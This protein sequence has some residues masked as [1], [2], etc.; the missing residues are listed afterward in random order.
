MKYLI[1]EDDPGLAQIIATALQDTTSQVD[2]SHN[3]REGL[4]K[5]QL[6]SYDAII[7]D[8]MLPEMSGINIVHHLRKNGNNT[9][10]MI[11]SALG[12][13]Q[14][15]IEGL[16]YGADDY[17]PKPFD[18]LELKLRVKN[19]LK[20]NRSTTAPTQ[21]SYK[22]L[23]LDRLTRT[24]Q[25]Q[26][27]PIELQEKEYMLL[28]LFLSHPTEVISKSNILKKVWNYDYDPD[29]NIVDVLVCRLRNKIEKDFQSRMIYTVRS[30]GYILK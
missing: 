26:G 16:S 25:R 7:A 29:T 15:R 6:N 27:R 11:V 19:L 9:P 3:G 18:L 12:E 2:T 10:L 14:N 8:V 1:I 5:A 30:V 13:P 17:L 21:L 4:E 24:A 23:S 28:E 22:D 20:K